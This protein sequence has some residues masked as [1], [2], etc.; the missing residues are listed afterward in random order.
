MIESNTIPPEKAS[1]RITLDLAYSLNGTSVDDLEAYVINTLTRAVENG[2]FPQVPGVMATIDRHEVF[3]EQQVLLTRDFAGEYNDYFIS[4][5]VN[6]T[7]WIGVDNM[8]LAIKREP[9]GVVFDVWP[10]YAAGGSVVST[11]AVFHDD[12]EG[13]QMSDLG[14]NP[15]E[16]V[17]WVSKTLGIDFDS[18][19]PLERARL[20]WQYHSRNASA[21]VEVAA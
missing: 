7:C 16:V 20:V 5:D 3:A 1:L 14:V 4:D 8:A 18:V 13:E 6:G 19:S 2:L 10:L 21:N 9:E 12:A 17:D 15:D 11:M